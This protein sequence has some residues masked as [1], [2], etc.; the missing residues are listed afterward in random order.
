MRWISSHCAS[1][2]SLSCNR[3]DRCAS[4]AKM[5]NSCFLGGGAIAARTRSESR[6]RTPLEWIH[7]RKSRSSERCV[8]ATQAYR[9]AHFDAAPCANAASF[10]RS[11][12]G[13]PGGPRN[14][15]CT[16]GACAKEA[17]QSNAH[18]CSATLCGGPSA[19]RKRRSS[20]RYDVLRDDAALP[21]SSRWGCCSARLLPLLLPLEPKAVRL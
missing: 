5:F 21:E 15:A 19:R 2:A 7:E 8:S 13:A 20:P 12:N 11:T 4:V 14:A 17:M 1:C 10:C 18:S 3:R 9:E 16:E 6:G